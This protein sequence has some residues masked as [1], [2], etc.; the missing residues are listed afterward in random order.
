MDHLTRLAEFFD[1]DQMLILKRE[2]FF[3]RP[4]EILQQVFGFL[5]LPEWEPDPSVFESK[6]NSRKYAKMDP[7]TRRKLEEFF[8][9]HSQRLYE[10]LGRALGW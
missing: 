7:G 5:G 10:Y 8:K 3:A 2:D 6:R 1:D 4:R 9:P